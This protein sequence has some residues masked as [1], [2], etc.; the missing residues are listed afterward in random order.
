M[1]T[2]GAGLFC[3][4]FSS[5]REN[6]T[7]CN[8]VWCG[9]CYKALDNGE[10]PIAK[11][12][13]EDGNT[14]NDPEEDARYMEARNGDNLL[15]PFQCDLCHFRNVM[16]RDPAGSPQDVRILKLIR[17][18]N[19]DALWSREP[20]TVRSTLVSCRQGGRIATY[21]GFR[22]EL[23]QPLGP[24]PIE[25]SFGMAP[26][27]VMLQLS[28]Q[29]GRNDKTVQFATVRKFRSAYSNV[30]HASARGQGAMVM[31]KD[32]RKLTVTQCPTYGEWFERFMRGMHKRMGEIARADR[33]L[34]LDV[35]KEIFSFLDRE[36]ENP[37]T[38]K[39]K[40][41]REGAF[42]V[43]T[44]CCALRGEEVHM[45]DLNG[46][47][48]HWK[49][50]EEHE[51][52]HVVVAL[53]GRFKG[54][55]G[56]A[57]HLLCLVD[58]TQHGLEPRKWVGRLLEEHL[59]LGNTSGPFFRDDKGSKVQASFFEHKFF[60]RL[61]QVRSVKP[62]LLA[63]VEDIEEEFG[64]SRS[65]RRGATSAAVN[66]GLPPDVI[67]ANNRWRKMHL[68]GA[69]KPSLAMRDH[70]TDVRLT[71]QQRLRFSRAL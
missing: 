9:R 5:S 54:E 70:Y 16:K 46:I 43:I 13:D 1:I 23:F 38:N 47:R 36:W 45:A 18:A 26:A 64:V 2:E 40:L 34:A 29:P 56:E 41:A 4:N 17:R 53:L 11:P 33:A 20:G 24:F 30:Y 66:N 37:H 14:I 10:F 49:A 6:W 39:M 50:G 27:I 42:Y 67:D 8:Q 62:H 51:L 59:K 22:D 57:Y 19:L 12:T 7:A 63:S 32:I 61:E 58:V 35:L 25:D 69:N 52:K 28:L 31:A 68:A 15:T 65:F 55:T 71:L 21:L 44:Y 3:G 60:D 48:K